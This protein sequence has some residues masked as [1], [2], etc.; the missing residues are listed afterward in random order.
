[1][2]DGSWPSAYP[3]EQTS[4]SSDEGV[5]ASARSTAG[6]VE[7]LNSSR[8]FNDCAS[9]PSGVMSRS[10]EYRC[11]GRSTLASLISTVTTVAWKFVPKASVWLVSLECSAGGLAASTSPS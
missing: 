3:S 1:M 9:P 8:A 11:P 5:P 6:N 4:T 10:Y 2:N 7:S